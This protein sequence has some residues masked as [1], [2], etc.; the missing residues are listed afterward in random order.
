MLEH[1]ELLVELGKYFGKPA[2]LW[3]PDAS[4]RDTRAA[5]LGCGSDSFSLY[6][7]I[8]LGNNYAA[9]GVRASP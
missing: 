8:D 2:R 9:R 6:A 1:P 7:N 3:M 5:W 4:C